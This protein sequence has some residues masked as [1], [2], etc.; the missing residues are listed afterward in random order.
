MKLVAENVGV[1]FLGAVL[2]VAAG[3]EKPPALPAEAPLESG[4]VGTYQKLGDDTYLITGH[5]GVGSVEAF[6]RNLQRFREEVS[7]H[8]ILTPEY[9]N[10][11]TW[12]MVAVRRR[13]ASND[14]LGNI[15]EFAP[16]A[17]Q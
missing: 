14:G 10:N 11:P 2:A 9:S 15:V 8:F 5:G 6:G 4:R 1:G 17:G 7:G 13:V 3:C 16:T 12:S